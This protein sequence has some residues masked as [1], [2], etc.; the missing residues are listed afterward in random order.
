MKIWKFQF[1]WVTHICWFSVYCRICCILHWTIL[2]YVYKKYGLSINNSYSPLL[3]PLFYS[4]TENAISSEISSTVN[5][6]TR[7]CRWVGEQSSCCFE[8]DTFGVRY[9]GYKKVFKSDFILFAPFF[10]FIL[11][12]LNKDLW[13]YCILLRYLLSKIRCTY[14]F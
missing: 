11:N 1:E 12:I 8:A 9:K 2:D 13:Y 6:W 10:Y 3:P 14:Y 4:Y 7:F 5:V